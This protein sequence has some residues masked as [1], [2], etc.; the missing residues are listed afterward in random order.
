MSRDHH[1]GLQVKGVKELHLQQITECC[2]GCV[3]HLSGGRGSRVGEEAVVT[4]DAESA[5]S[6][7]VGRGVPDGVQHLLKITG[8][9]ITIENRDLHVP[10]VVDVQGFLQADHQS[11]PVQLHRQDCVAVAVLAYLSPYNSRIVTS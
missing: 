5:E 1:L 3:T 11:R 8:R 10:D 4:V 7:G 9:G 6:S 2:Q